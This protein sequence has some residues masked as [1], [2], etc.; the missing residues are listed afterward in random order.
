MWEILTG[1]QKLE[2]TKKPKVEDETGGKKNF[3]KKKVSDQIRQK[4][5]H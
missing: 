4:F 5:N 1:P 3:P 2:E